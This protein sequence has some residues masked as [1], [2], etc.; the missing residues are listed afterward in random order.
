M[1]GLGGSG[2]VIVK[3]LG[4]EEEFGQEKGDEDNY[5][6]AWSVPRGGFALERGV[7]SVVFGTLGIDWRSAACPATEGSAE[8]VGGGRSCG[9]CLSATLLPAA[10]LLAT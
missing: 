10:L 9:D 5:S 7:W 2:L 3:G 4:G 6:E 1:V 8:W